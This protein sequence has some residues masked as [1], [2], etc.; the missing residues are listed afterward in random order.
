MDQLQRVLFSEVP[1]IR[2]SKAY[3]EPNMAADLFEANLKKL[4]QL[5]QRGRESYRE[6]EPALKNFF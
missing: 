5:Y 1:T 3:T 2:I 6:F 4:D